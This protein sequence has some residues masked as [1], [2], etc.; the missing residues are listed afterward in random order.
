MTQ[1]LATL[2]G[3]FPASFAGAPGDSASSCDACPAV[4]TPAA[5]RV[6]ILDSTS[7]GGSVV[8]V[9]KA[10][11]AVAASNWAT[12]RL[13]RWVWRSQREPAMWALVVVVLEE[14][15]EYAAEVG[16]VD[17]QEPVEAFA[18]HRSDESL[19]VRVGDG[20]T[21]RGADHADAFAREDFLKDAGEL[22]VAIANQEP[23]PVERAGDGQTAGLLCD[24]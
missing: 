7:G 15:D 20:G 3:L 13:I 8:L 19:C 5:R 22:A 9:E 6:P 2:F 21:D 18:A 1:Q 4:L 24:P 10:V 16:F 23:K 17:D 12:A 14:V 11:E